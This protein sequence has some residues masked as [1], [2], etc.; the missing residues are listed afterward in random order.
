MAQSKGYVNSDFHVCRLQKAIYGLQ[1]AA[2]V[3][4]EALI[5]HQN[6]IDLLSLN[7]ISHYSSLILGYHCVFSGVY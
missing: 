2:H 5:S 3:W 7:Q 6:T 1:Q 4:Y